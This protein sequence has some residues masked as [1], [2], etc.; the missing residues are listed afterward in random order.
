MADERVMRE[1][2]SFEAHLGRTPVHTLRARVGLIEHELCLKLEKANP[3]GSVKDRTAHQLVLS[4]AEEGR[5]APGKTIVESTSGNLGVALANLAREL[6]LSM[7]AVVDPTATAENVSR[8]KNLGA[9]VVVVDAKDENG[10]YLMS[11]LQLV[12]ELA[13]RNG[14]VWPNQYENA[15]NPRAHYRSTGPEIFEFAAES[16]LDAAFVAVSTGGTFA[17]VERFL[18]EQAAGLPVVPVDI[19]GSVVF[20]HGHGT[21]HIPGLGSSRK[22]DFIEDPARSH[23]PSIVSTAEASAACREVKVR[24]GMSIGGSS[25]AVVAAALLY[26]RQTARPS[27]VLCLC[28]DSGE[29]YQSTIFDDAWT[30]RLNLPPFEEIFRDVVLDLDVPPKISGRTPHL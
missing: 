26:L 21:R 20:G 2:A 16:R 17:G 9:E 4:L 11:R 8:L 30:V 15:A 28:A 7:V 18:R 23:R 12:R 3:T 25:G 29:S 5:L 24:S 19:V 22:S 14:Y 13:Q 1:L 10:G 6:G 27:R